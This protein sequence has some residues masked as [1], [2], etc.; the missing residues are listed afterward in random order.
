MFDDK[1]EKSQFLREV[2]IEETTNKVSRINLLMDRVHTVNTL[3]LIS[4]MSQIFLGSF[5][6][7]LSI[8]GVIKPIWL[9]TIISIFG[10]I[11]M[12]IGLFFT[13]QIFSEADAFNTLLHR[14]I[15]RVINSQN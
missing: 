8:L 7:A 4:A 5:V 10:S 11:T 3:H 13:Y 2:H 6:V 9:S 15:K 14:A 1:K 12:V